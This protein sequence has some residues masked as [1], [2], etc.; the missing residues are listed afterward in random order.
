MAA[1]IAMIA[2]TTR[3]SIN[4]NAHWREVF[5]FHLFV[6]IASRNLAAS[7][8]VPRL[9]SPTGSQDA[10]PLQETSFQETRNARSLE[11][12]RQRA[13]WPSSRLLKI[14]IFTSEPSG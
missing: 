6:L 4:V 12:G 1:R 14:A 13:D 3:S 7:L 2:I 8:G 10:S 9:P 5:A 11:A